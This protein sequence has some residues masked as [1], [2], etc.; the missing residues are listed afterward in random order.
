[1]K[2]EETKRFICW[3]IAAAV[4]EKSTLRTSQADSDC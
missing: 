4:Y 3:R 1:M 2:K